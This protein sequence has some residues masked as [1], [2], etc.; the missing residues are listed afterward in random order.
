MDES[1]LHWHLHYFI[2]LLIFLPA[3]NDVDIGIWFNRFLSD[4]SPYLRHDSVHRIDRRSD[5]RLK[6]RQIFGC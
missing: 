2:K 5:V 3:V 1:H 6:L 4:A